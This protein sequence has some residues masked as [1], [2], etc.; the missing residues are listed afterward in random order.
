MPL[1]KYRNQKSLKEDF[2]YLKP[3]FQMRTRPSKA[4]DYIELAFRISNN[5]AT[6]D[7]YKYAVESSGFN[8]R[9]ETA[10]KELNYRV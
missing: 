8:K 6:M 10:I 2:K 4:L 7:D 5:I 3:I 9:N 1:K